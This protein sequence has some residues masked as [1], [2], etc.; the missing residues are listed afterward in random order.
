MFILLRTVEPTGGFL[1]RRRLKKKIANSIPISVSTE[2]GMPFYVLDVFSD[3]N[4]PDYSVIEERSGYY[5]SRIVAPRTLSLPDKSNLKRFLPG[6]SNGIFIFNTAVDI[7]KETDPEPE[8]ISATVIDRNAVMCG[9]I[10][11]LIPYSSPLRIITS[12]PERYASICRKIYDEY[13][14]SVLLRSFYEP[15]LKK[16]IVICCDGTTSDSMRNA[17]VFSFKRGTNGKLRFYGSRIPL[18]DFYKKI[19]PENIDS[20]DFA[21]A[22]TELC[23]STTYKAAV[24]SDIEINCRKCGKTRPSECLECYISGAL[25]V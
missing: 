1:N 3:K 11:K 6:Y 25:T 4:G 13:G 18:S 8:K 21:A 9:E 17:A 10:V 2:N 16:D 5:A 24:Y 22:V 12:R 14:V 23:G 7:I 19:I 15:S 20:T